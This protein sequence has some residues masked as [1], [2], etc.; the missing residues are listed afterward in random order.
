[1]RHSTI[2]CRWLGWKEEEEAE[3]KDQF[4]STI[5]VFKTFYAFPSSFYG[6]NQASI[7]VKGPTAA[8]SDQ[9]ALFNFTLHV[10]QR[11]F[12]FLCVFPFW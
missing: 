5:N 2:V 7:K 6:G 11:V 12:S 8:E 1:M 4:R 3:E 10:V 9:Q